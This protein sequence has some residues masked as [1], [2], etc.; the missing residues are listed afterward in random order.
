MDEAHLLLT[1]DEPIVRKIV[2]IASQTPL[3]TPSQ[4]PLQTP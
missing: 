3:Q 2:I 1:D 4:T